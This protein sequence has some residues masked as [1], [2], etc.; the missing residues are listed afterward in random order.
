MTIRRAKVKM[1]RAKERKEKEFRKEKKVITRAKVKAK[2]K[3]AKVWQHVAL[4]ES[5][6]ILL[7]EEQFSTGSK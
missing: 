2:T 5:Q 7:M 1:L 6:D 4:V 3:K